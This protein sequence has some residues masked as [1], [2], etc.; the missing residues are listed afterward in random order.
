MIDES[1]R[2]QDFINA[3]NVQSYMSQG[4]KRVDGVWAYQVYD[5]TENNSDAGLVK[6]VSEIQD[7][8]VIYYKI[9]AKQVIPIQTRIERQVK[10]TGYKTYQSDNGEIIHTGA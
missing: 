8:K 2:L 5:Y 1:T 7:G 3:L 9:P 6:L 4:Y 10:R